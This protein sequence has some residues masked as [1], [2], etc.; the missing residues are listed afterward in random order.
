MRLSLVGIGALL[1][2]EDGY[3]KISELIPGGPAQIDGQLKVNDKIVAVGQGRDGKLVD[4]I[5]M[6]L[7]EVVEMIRGK[8]G[9]VVHL[10]VVPADGKARKSID[11]VRDEVKL[12]EQ[13]AKAEIIEMK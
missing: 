10:Q 4:T 3:A 9:T 1:R 8:K 13:Q 5:D 11:I 6:R 7:D 2:S 12:T